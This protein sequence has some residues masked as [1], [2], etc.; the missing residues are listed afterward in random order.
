VAAQELLT[1]ANVVAN[2]NFHTRTKLASEHD[3]EKYNWATSSQKYPTFMG[4]DEFGVPYQISSR[5]VLKA[6]GMR[7]MVIYTSTSLVSPRNASFS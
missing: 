4:R 1:S 5:S 2:A 7:D 6:L 3:H